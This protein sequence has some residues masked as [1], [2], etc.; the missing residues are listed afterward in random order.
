MEKLSYFSIDDV[1]LPYRHNVFLTI[2]KPDIRKEGVLKPGPAGSTDDMGACFYGTVLHDGGKYRM[3]Y[4]ACHQGKN[5]DYPPKMMQQ[6]AKPPGYYEGETDFF[7]GPLCYAESED[8]IKWTK[9]DLSQY[10]F[11]GTVHNNALLLPHAI[12]SGASVIKDEEDPDPKR[13]YKMVYQ[14][15]PDQSDPVIEEFGTSPTVATAVSPDGIVWTVT[16]MPFINQFVEH[17]SFMKH[18]GKYIIHYH[19]MGDWG[20]MS[21]GGA[22]SGRTGV[23]RISTDFDFWPDVWVDTFA[24]A[25]PQ[26][27]KLRGMK[28]EYDQVHLGVGAASMG[29]VSIGIYG[30]WHNAD[31]DTF[32]KISC[33]LGIV[34]SNDGIHFR[35]P[36]KG[37]V[38]IHRNESPSPD[39]PGFKINTNLCQGNGIL[40]VGNQTLVYH[41]RWR[42]A[43]EHYESE[44]NN[45]FSSEVALATL[46]LDRWGSISLIP[47]KDRGVVYSCLTELG[48]NER[49]SLN[50]DGLQNMEVCLLD[51]NFRQI[52]GYCGALNAAGSSFD[53]PVVWKNGLSGLRGKKVYIQVSMKRGEP[54]PKLYAIYVKR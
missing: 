1:S 38:Y 32:S 51:E 42:N 17:C 23:A 4:Y 24:L 47:G 45:L 33:D 18:D 3:W 15:F 40:N 20:H 14:Y 46:P 5:P 34:I 37:Y 27:H 41:G 10:L 49:I 43:G 52:P 22:Q 25:E 6:V 36:V 54:E 29:N 19:V 7:Q 28:T 12:V 26:D 11:K 30:L 48:G 53:A 35:E 8:G 21:E 44:T 9:P 2:T 39:V 31:F 50:A 13:R 16:G